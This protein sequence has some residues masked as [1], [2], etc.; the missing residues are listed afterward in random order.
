MVSLKIILDGDGSFPE[1]Q[2]K[3]IHTTQEEITVTALGGGMASGKPSVALV[4]PLPDGSVMFA[5]TSLALFLSAAEVLKA[6]WGDP[7]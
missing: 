3:R 2:Q 1:L 7:R 5:E 4:I 6:K